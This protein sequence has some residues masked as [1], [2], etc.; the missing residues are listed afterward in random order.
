MT[1]V[2]VSRGVLDWALQRSSLTRDDLRKKFP[3]IDEWVAGTTNPTVKQLEEFSRKTMTPFGYLLLPEPPTDELPIPEFRTLDDE[4]TPGHVSPNLLDTVQAM[5]RRQ[6]WMREFLVENGQPRLPFIGSAASDED[7]AKIAEDIRRT[8]GV[9]R[10]WASRLRTWTDAIRVLKDLA[11]AAGVLVV[12]N[13]IVGNNT[14]RKLDPTEFRGFVLSDEYAPLIFVN[15]ADAKGAQIFTFAHE[16]AHLWFA[17]SAAFDLR[18]L[19]PA[20]DRIERICNWVAAEFLLPREELLH[21]WPLVAE[22]P[23]PFQEL[24]KRFKVSSLVAARRALDIGVIGRAAFFEFYE[25]YLVDERRKKVS[26]ESTGG[27]YYINQDY[28]VG[29]KFGSAVIRATLEGRLLYREAYRL[30]DLGPGAFDKYA[31]H[32]G[33]GPSDEPSARLSARRKRLHRGEESLLRLRHLPRLLA[34]AVMEPR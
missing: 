29:H 26:D 18:A 21:S 16:L 10:L 2:A 27:H 32:L 4:G 8:L 23:E 11:E 31:A 7:P 6:D 25:A 33:I 22:S 9:E 28:R 1:R 19:Q 15:G 20:D 34:V 17:K 14:W 13:G 5:L 3:K 24:A 12:V 30:T